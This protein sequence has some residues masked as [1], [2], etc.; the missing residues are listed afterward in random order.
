MRSALPPLL[1]LYAALALALASAPR[2]AW[3]PCLGLLAA[4]AFVTITTP[5]PWHEGVFVGCWSSVA[6]TAAGGL[7][8]RTDRQLA[9]GLSVNAGLW[10][11]ALAA[12][13][14]APLEP[15]AALPALGLLPAAAWA[16][17]HLSFPAVRVMSS[18][19]VAVAVLAVTL[20]CLPVTPGYLP[21]HLE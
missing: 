15:L 1:L 14:G 7:I 20:A 9:W 2:R 8:C 16:L 4:T 10:S 11:G 12:V 3:R 18:W 19:L 21:D 5:P 6:V 17:R 13:T